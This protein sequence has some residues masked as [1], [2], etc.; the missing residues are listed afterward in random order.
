M[1]SLGNGLE[2]WNIVAGV[3]NG[4]EI[5]GLGLIINGGND[6]LNLVSLNKLGSDTKSWEHN[7]ELV[8][9]TT[10]QVASGDNVITSVS[11]GRNGHEL[12]GLARGGSNGSNTTFQGSN[13]LFEDIYSGVHNATVDITELLEAEEPRAVSGVIEDVRACSVDGDSA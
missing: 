2:V 10:V 3:T 5:N 1:N 7:L 9:G 13:S 8:I 12:R 4:L 11:E 6:V